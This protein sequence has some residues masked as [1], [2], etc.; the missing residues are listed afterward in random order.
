MP[1]R[2][3]KYEYNPLAP[4][5]RRGLCLF[6]GEECSGNAGLYGWN[7][8]D[9]KTTSLRPLCERLPAP[10]MELRDPPEPGAV[11]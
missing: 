4:R 1:T 5:D 6:C 10:A 7:G 3:G 11:A 9:Q 8:V 2:F